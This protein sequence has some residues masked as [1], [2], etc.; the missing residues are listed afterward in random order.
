MRGAFGLLL[1]LTCVSFAGAAAPT[2]K[3]VLFFTKSSGFE[4]SAIKRIAG[5]P[6]FAM[7]VLNELG[8]KHR[9][10]F[11]ESK[12][13]SLFTPEYLAQFD[14]FLFYT[15]GDLTLAKNDE[16]QGD[17][18]PPMTAA[19]KAAFL[20]AISDGKVFSARIAPAIRFTRRA[21]KDTVQPA[22]RTTATSSMTTP[23]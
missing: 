16:K 11:T 10:E 23:E 4:H 8:A 5:N 14:A 19:G 22:T 9:I 20:Q 15:S 12:D 21:T 3:K 7:Q 18:N 6:S 1:S 2:A 17:G 13:G